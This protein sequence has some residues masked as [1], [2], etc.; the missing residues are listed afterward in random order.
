MTHPKPL[1]L[2]LLLGA[3]GWGAAKPATLTIQA[4]KPGHAI[5]PML[6]GI[7]FE[8]INRSGDGGLYA[9]MLQNPSF[10]DFNLPMGWTALN[11]GGSSSTLT[12]D[13]SQ[14]L[15]A[16]NP[17]SLRLDVTSAG[18][19]AGVNN[20]G[21]KGAIIDSQYPVTNLPTPNDPNPKADYQNWMDRF[22]EA[23]KRPDNG[24][25]LETGKGY[26]GSLEARADG[27]FSG[28]LTV[29]LEKQDG[30]LLATQDLP[31]LGP[32][33]KK[34]DF[35]LKPTASDTNAR[36]VVATKETGTLWL[37]MVSLF[38][39]DTFNHRPNGLRADLMDMLVALHPAFVRFPA[40]SFG[41]GKN[42]DEAFRWKD[43]IGD[44][45]ARPGVWNIWG[46]RTTN[47]LGFYEYLQ[48][49]E[50]LKAE[51]LFVINCGISE[52]DMVEPKDLGP[53]IQDA[54]DC[55]D[56]ANGPTTGTW[57]ALRAQ[58]G[59]PEPFNMK[60]LEIGNENGMGYFWGGGNA[61]QYA[62]RYNPFY[63]KVKAAYPDLHT[64]ATAP[65]QKPPVSSTVESVDEHYYESSGWFQD[66]ATM[67]DNY[68]RSGP[69]IY[70]GE[71]ACKSDAGNGNL[72]AALGEAVFMTGME[73]NSDV[74]TMASYAP[75]FVNPSWRAWNPNLI[76]FDSSRAY[77]TPSYYN[78]MLFAA[79]RPDVILPIEI[80]LPEAGDPKARKTLYAVAGKMKTTGEII[81][82]AV[83]TSDQPQD[84]S[85]QVKGGEPGGYKIHAIVLSSEKPSDENSFDEPT[86]ILPKESDPDLTSTASDIETASFLYT[87]APYS[88]TVLHLKN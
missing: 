54:I 24:L 56:Y 4:D 20:Q 48:M 64:I 19:R 82:K 59:H 68:D 70:V 29:S 5:S 9:E 21:Y 31:P 6:Y 43:T 7:F 22:N 38:P 3:P 77:G 27:N 2:L 60:Y 41:E 75:L 87:F 11:E 1:F 50:D 51:P 88:I 76:V 14:P 15:N 83:N 53:W 34:Y 36:F 16:K 44:L 23:Q 46:Y 86:K 80:N 85:I 13:K 62:D 35:A 52:T 26:H 45:A 8:D 25:C 65:I 42:L 63:E 47:G 71:Y 10:E 33:W 37:D 81:L 72:N 69:K 66:H 17:N 40:G 39:D 18:G 78:Q 58:A 55:V 74:V 57:G 49:C 28:T 12:L 73:R 30:T 84:A 79:N 67:Y 32:D 61:R